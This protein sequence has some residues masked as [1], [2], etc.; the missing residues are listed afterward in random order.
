MHNVNDI[1][2]FRKGDIVTITRLAKLLKKTWQIMGC[3]KRSVLASKAFY[4]RS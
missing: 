4:F 2:T 3:F 1:I